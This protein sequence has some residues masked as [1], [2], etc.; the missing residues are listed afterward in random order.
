LLGLYFDPDEVE[1][2][3]EMLGFLPTTHYNTDDYISHYYLELIP[4]DGVTTLSWWWGLSAP[5]AARAMLAVA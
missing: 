5:E 3:P 1:C 2:S 4:T